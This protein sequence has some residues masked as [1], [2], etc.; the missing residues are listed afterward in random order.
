MAIVRATTSSLHWQARSLEILTLAAFG[1]LFFLVPDGTD[2]WVLIANLGTFY[3]VFLRALA[4]PDR[5]L[6][7]LPSY[8]SIEVL[9][10]AYSYLIF[11]Y[12]YQLSL[13]G[14]GDIGVS[15]YLI[16]SYVDG[17]NKAITL[18]TVGMLAFVI[19]Y[20]VLGGATG[21][22]EAAE[23][24]PSVEH[25]AREELRARYFRAMSTASSTLLLALIALYVAAGWRT[26]GEGRYTGTTSGGLGIEGISIIIMMLCMIVAALWVYAAASKLAKPTILVFG[27]VVTVGWTL[28]WLVLGDR[29]SFLLVALIFVGGYCTFVRRTSLAMVAVT[30]AMW[31]FVYSTIEVVRTVPN[32]YRAGN[33]WDLFEM[34]RNFQG[35]SDESSF[36]VTTIALRATVE[37]VPNAHD[38][39]Y[40]SFK[41]VQFFSAVP[42]SGRFYLPYLNPEYLS[43]ADLLSDIILGPRATWGTGTNVI[44]DSYVDFGMPGVV[45]ILFCIG[46][47]AKVIRNYVARDPHDAHRVIVY[48]L[49]MSMFAQLPR[50]AIEIPI[51][52]LTWA[53]VFSVIVRVFAR[54]GHARTSA[55]HVPG[56]VHG[57]RS[58]PNA[59]ASE[60]RRLS[61]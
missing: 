16:D 55:R 19:G 48:L 61:L 27:F 22:V 54:R 58:R 39:A 38:F 43:S 41:V 53:V 8:F 47:F 31:M 24:P 17:S 28:R 36:N 23:M 45:A 59:A 7:W 12:P 44:S 60:H 32:W 52:V 1:A 11:Y 18:T 14:I 50:Y 35:S 4:I 57:S 37:T 2:P 29:N 42:F 15:R 34:A 6:P 13:F 40:G 51:R 46:L 3:V 30:F 33:I 26:A 9:F 5:I 25:P 56:T 20:R 21:D 49:T 10:L